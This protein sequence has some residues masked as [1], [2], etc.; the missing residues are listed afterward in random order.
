MGTKRKGIHYPYKLETLK[1]ISFGKN[2]IES[3]IRSTPGRHGPFPVATFL[4]QVKGSMIDFQTINNE[5]LL[6]LYIA[7]DRL[8]F[9]GIKEIPKRYPDVDVA[10]LHLGA[11]QSCGSCYGC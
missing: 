11:L 4:P 1:D 9:D 7:G 5:H 2:D 6:R 10:L 8:V 3:N